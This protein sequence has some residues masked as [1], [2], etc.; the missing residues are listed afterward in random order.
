MRDDFWQSLIKR[1]QN[2]KKKRKNQFPMLMEGGNYNKCCCNGSKILQ[3]Q[4]RWYT[5]IEYTK[6]ANSIKGILQQH[7]LP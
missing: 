5:E 6:I 1:Q 4:Y 7:V 3:A 2:K